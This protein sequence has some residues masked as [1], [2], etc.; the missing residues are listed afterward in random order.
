MMRDF[1]DSVGSERIG[2]ELS[3]ALHGKGAFRYFKDT[4]RRH[5]MESAW[6]A[7]RTEALA[8][9][10]RDWCKENHVEWR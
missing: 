3:N 10:A 4:L 6:Y 2:E 9:M 1:A 8:Q 7:F 5:R